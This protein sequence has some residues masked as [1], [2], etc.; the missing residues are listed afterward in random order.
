MAP[1]KKAGSTKNSKNAKKKSAPEGAIQPQMQ[2]VTSDVCKKCPSV[3][4]RGAIYMEKM[5]QRGSI[6]YGVPCM[7]RKK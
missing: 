3:C 4:T 6:G 1:G 5:S 2:I 7:L